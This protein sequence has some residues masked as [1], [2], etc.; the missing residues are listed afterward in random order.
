MRGT[1]AIKKALNADGYGKV[2]LL[3]GM[4]KEQLMYL[5]EML[6]QIPDDSLL[7]CFR[8]R[9][10]KVAPG[11]PLNGWYGEGF[12]NNF[13][14]FIAAYSRMAAALGDIR[15]REKTE[16]LLL[17]FEN[18]IEPDGF[19]FNSR[20]ANAPLY[21][22]DKMAGGLVDAY[23]FAGLYEPSARILK[24]ITEFHIR[25][26]DYSNIYNNMCD[27]GPTEWYT[28]PEN[29][30]RAYLLF[31]DE[32]YRDFADR[33][34]YDEYFAYYQ[35]NDHEGMMER[36][37]TTASKRYHA[38]SH[39]NTLGSAAMKYYVSGDE[40]YLDTIRNAYDIIR[41]KQT[42]ATGGFGPCETFMYPYQRMETLYSEMMHC[43]TPC[44][45]WA[46]FK[47]VRQLI[48][49]TGEA[50]YGE[51]AEAQIYNNIGAAPPLRDDGFVMYFADYG[52][53]HA[54][55]R[56]RTPWSCCSGTTTMAIP[57]Y[58]NQIY[59]TQS[60]GIMVNLYIPSSIDINNGNTKG[61][62]E[63]RTSFPCSE[64]SYFVFSLE[65]T[66]SLKL[67]FRIPAWLA[68]EMEISLNEKKA[69][70]TEEK[71][72]AVL[73]AEFR[74]GDVVTVRLPMGFRKKPV[75]EGFLYPAAILYGPVVMVQPQCNNEKQLVYDDVDCVL[76]S[77]VRADNEELVFL[78][79]APDGR[80]V[81]LVPYFAMEA[82]R[83]FQMYIDKNESRIFPDAIT[84]GPDES[85]WEEKHLWL[86]YPSKTGIASI[87]YKGAYFEAHFEGTG[88][89]WIGNQ[90]NTAGYADIC[91]DETFVETITQYSGVNGSPWIWAK[92]DLSAGKH[93][94]RVTAK[95]NAP[96]ES[97]GCSIN[98]KHL[99]VLE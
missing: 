22:Y 97:C 52:L 6:Y 67:G 37:K 76:K 11:K 12:Y 72:W 30:Y 3:D 66:A 4:H 42:F 10:Q 96:G 47:L 43:E 8:N 83:P 19:W 35:N 49:Y 61:K 39:T 32:M 51:W 31:G 87:E 14:Q 33:F 24:R 77:V 21:S 71:G 86:D 68:G 95:D 91:I 54:A 2:Q 84:F 5:S 16:R 27:V 73:A 92:T 1:T 15:F 89:L 69:E 60:D 9:N 93:T 18:E 50:R 7:F 98:V 40:K 36:V 29:L 63:Q 88:I 58:V 82:E 74:D 94:I 26:T 41:E 46:V 28:L 65:E 80:P 81:E 85:A 79:K 75:E 45:S 78:A 62:I 57:E 20:L 99:R 17:G 53:D 38:Y 64:Y 44:T 13:G 23:E 48:E 34:L 25:Y 90:Q 70:W 59:Y 55:K 56:Y